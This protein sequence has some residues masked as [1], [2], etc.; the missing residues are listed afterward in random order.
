MLRG[1]AACETFY[2][3][4]EHRPNQAGFSAYHVCSDPDSFSCLHSSDIIHFN[5]PTITGRQCNKSATDTHP[6]T[7]T[8]Q[9]TGD[10]TFRCTIND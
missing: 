1:G 2:Y 7:D 4:I 5:D 3:S 8:G 6:A 9:Y 10:H